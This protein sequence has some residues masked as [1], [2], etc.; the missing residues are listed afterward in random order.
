MTLISANS[1]DFVSTSIEPA[2]LLDDDVVTDREPKSR[3]FSSRFRRE[4]RIEHLLFD[5][6]RDSGSV[7]ANPDFDAVAE[8]LGRCNQ[9][10]SWPS[11]FI[12]ALRFAAA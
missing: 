10:R 4:E 3:A 11:P 1:P 6:G 8:I 9:G 12:S 7:V 5:V 2:M